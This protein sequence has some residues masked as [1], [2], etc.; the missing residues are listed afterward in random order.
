MRSAA[1]HLCAGFDLSSELIPIDLAAGVVDE[2]VTKVHFSFHS[3]DKGN[4]Q[5]RRAGRQVQKVSGSPQRATRGAVGPQAGCTT[6]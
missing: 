6:A 1:I 3:P 5:T 4:R 2:C